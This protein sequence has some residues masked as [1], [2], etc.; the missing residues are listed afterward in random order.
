MTGHPCYT[1]QKVFSYSSLVDNAW[2]IE[3][4]SSVEV[5]CTKFNDTFSETSSMMGHEVYVEKGKST[6]I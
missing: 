4:L 6:G 3:N 1:T 5:T 2:Y